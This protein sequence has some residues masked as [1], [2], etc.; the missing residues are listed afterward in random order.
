[1]PNT[2]IYIIIIMLFN[3]L[4]IFGDRKIK[5]KKNQKNETN[6]KNEIKLYN[7]KILRAFFYLANDQIYNSKEVYFLNKFLLKIYL[8]YAKYTEW[9]IICIGN[10]SVY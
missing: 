2:Y 9:F 3:I 4:L 10:H 6:K 5:I 1:M 8:K 7:T